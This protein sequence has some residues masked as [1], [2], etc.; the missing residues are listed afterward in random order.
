MPD[1]EV[2][3]YSHRQGKAIK[4]LRKD[5]PDNSDGTLCVFYTLCTAY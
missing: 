3:A 1:R 5:R 2:Y 4:S